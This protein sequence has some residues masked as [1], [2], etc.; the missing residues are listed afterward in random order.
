M[1]FAQ[2]NMNRHSYSFQEVQQLLDGAVDHAIPAFVSP[3][4]GF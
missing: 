3:S 1:L 2:L 4:A